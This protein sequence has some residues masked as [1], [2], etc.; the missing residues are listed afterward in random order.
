[1]PSAPK[2]SD[3]A[4]EVAIKA[5]KEVLQ[6]AAIQAAAAVAPYVGIG[7]LIILGIILA[8]FLVSILAF[9]TLYGICDYAPRTMGWVT[10]W[11]NMGDLCAIVLNK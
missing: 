5:A 7:C 4:K 9:L 6:K 1:M 2:A 3:V 8:I 11:Y 10:W